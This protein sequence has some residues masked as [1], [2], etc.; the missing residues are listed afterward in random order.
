M[1]IPSAGTPVS[2]FDLLR[3]FFP[4]G[5]VQSFATH[6]KQTL[7]VAWCG[8][9]GSGTSSIYATLCAL[10]K[11]SNAKKIVL[12]CYT[13]PSLI[14]PI[15]KAGLEPVLCDISPETL[16]AGP[17]EIL[18]CI[19]DNT[20]AIMPVHM[21]GLP[22]DVPHM[23]KQLKNSGVFVIEDAASAMGARIDGVQ[24]G[25]RSDI[26]IYSFNR[27]KN[28]ATYT[29]GALLSTRED[30]I[31]D[32]ESAMGI[33]PYPNLAYALKIRLFACALAAVVR[34]R[35]YTLL[36]G[37]ADR[38]KYTTLHT[39]FH[40]WAYTNFQARLGKSVFR[41]LET[42]TQIR[43][44]NAQFLRDELHDID[45]VRLPRILKGSRP[46]YNQFPLLLPDE[47]TREAVHRAILETGTESTLLYP[48]P[49]HRLYPD[50]WNGTGPDPYPNATTVARRLLLVPIHPLV[51]QRALERA[52][53]AIAK[54]LKKT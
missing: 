30:L 42:F 21:F 44:N 22:T 45:G 4:M 26:G 18:P 25:T 47:S 23:S 49:I 50:I 10:Q 51:P 33:Y 2:I 3:A 39:D 9:S 54:T 5:G 52:A 11:H 6:L 1:K 19:D 32:L 17:Q 16:N 53:D 8:L 36:Q 27:G 46:A 14:L 31:P 41:N 12:P 43:E 13:A 48:D 24:V 34:P 35:A 28:M 37:L 29:G 7:D 38:F 15:R 40:T 20:L